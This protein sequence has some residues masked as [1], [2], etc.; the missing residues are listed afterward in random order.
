MTIV[1]PQCEKCH[2]PVEAVSFQQKLIFRGLFQE[3][4]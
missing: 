3:G 1:W 2:A 4:T